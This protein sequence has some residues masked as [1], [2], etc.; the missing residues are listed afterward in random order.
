MMFPIGWRRVWCVVLVGAGAT[1]V[2]CGGVPVERK[3]PAQE[4][5]VRRTWNEALPLVR[6]AVLEAFERNRRATLP[7]PFNQMVAIELTLPRYS[8]DWLVTYVDPG[9]FLKDYKALPPAIRSNDLWV[10]DPVGDTYWP[11]EYQGPDGPVRFHCGFIL[12]FVDAT[13]GTTIEAYESVPEIWPGEHW[14][15]AMHGI[16]FGRFHDIR[17]VEPTVQDR[18]RV[19]DLIDEILKKRG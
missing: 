4:R 6:S 9:D 13:V 14:A 11:S 1:A 7:D 10:E 17:F 15:W 19:L 3:G 2:G 5:S 18:I 12:H 16:G 8:P